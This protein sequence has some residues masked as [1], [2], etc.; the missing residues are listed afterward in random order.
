MANK[1]SLTVNSRVCLYE[2]AVQGCVTLLLFKKKKKCLKYYS[3][4]LGNLLVY[5]Q[6]D[7][8]VFRFYTDCMKSGGKIELILFLLQKTQPCGHLKQI[9]I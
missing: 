8:W 1:M 7:E 3:A 2:L 4:L 9:L 6:K 5:F